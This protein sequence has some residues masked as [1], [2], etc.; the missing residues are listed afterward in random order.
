MFNGQFQKEV[1]TLR[2]SSCS[3]FGF[4]EI[5][6]VFLADGLPIDLHNII[7]WSPGVHLENLRGGRGE[8][9]NQVSQNYEGQY[10]ILCSLGWG[11]T[12]VWGGGRRG[13]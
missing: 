6:H 1:E 5:D 3:Q 2:K 10:I 11:S 9:N 4:I 12:K 7:M 13:F 8:G